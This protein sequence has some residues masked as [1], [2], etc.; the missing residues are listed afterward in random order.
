MPARMWRHGIHSFL[1]L[2]RHRLPDSLEHMLAF[3]YLAYSMMTLLLESVISFEETWIECLGDLARYRM[4]IEEVD[5][6]D[7]ETWAGVA[8]MWY[9]KAADK[10]PTV[11]RIQHHLAVLARPNIVQQAFYY[12]KSLT[13][14]APFQN[15]KESIA[16]LFN[17]FLESNEIASQRYPP[18]EA[19]FVKA[20]GMLF[21]DWPIK[22]HEE[23][24]VDFC[25]N[26]LGN[27]IGR[28]TAKFKT[29]GPEMAICLCS[30]TFYF[31]RTD[32]FLPE[33]FRAQDYI[34]KAITDSQRIPN[35][36]DHPIDGSR[37]YPTSLQK[38][39]ADV[40]SLPAW[41]ELQPNNERF[42][43]SQLVVEQAFRSLAKVIVEVSKRM[44]DRNIVPFFHVVLAY[45][46][47]VA[48]IPPAFLY[49]KGF[50]PWYAIAFFL[51]TLGRSGAVEARYEGEEFPTKSG[52]TGHVPE[53]DSLR[54]L[55]FCFHYYPP[56][57]FDGQVTN[58]QERALEKPSHAISRAERCLWLAFRLTTVSFS[59]NRSSVIKFLQVEGCL[60]YDPETKKFSAANNIPSHESIQ[61][62]FSPD[63]RSPTMSLENDPDT[64][65]AGVDP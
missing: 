16:L 25:N 8:R 3:V 56:G 10:S 51:S 42:A 2:L 5:P 53:D 6:R 59:E 64:D 33:V 62:S 61:D 29:Q 28:V 48:F 23:L 22:Q 4:A 44:G 9:N 17:P 47:G 18:P 41:G 20:L 27:H 60:H 26:Y 19:M 36:D 15:A 31:G 11:G 21:K 1:E 63:S 35:S 43:A 24:F 55:M 52:S 13:S 34:K 38:A 46:Y 37:A 65:M 40:D 30:A 58:D 49:V 57:F 14:V 54:G 45:L 50:I 32:A 12:C 39:W 7:R